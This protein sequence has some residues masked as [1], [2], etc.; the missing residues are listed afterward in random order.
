MNN[1]ETTG[2]IVGY[3]VIWILALGLHIF[4]SHVIGKAAERRGRNYW[5]F[6]WL[7]FLVSWV[8]MGIIVAVLPY[9]HEHS[10][11]KNRSNPTAPASDKTA[12]PFCAED[13]KVQAL[14]CKHCGRDIGDALKDQ[15]DAFITEQ[16]HAARD[17]PNFEGPAFE[18]RECG[19]FSP[20]TSEDAELPDN[21]PSCGTGAAFL[22]KYVPEDAEPNEELAIP[23][24]KIDGTHL[25]CRSC[26]K[27]SEFP[28]GSH[29]IP[30]GCPKC[31][32]GEAFLEIVK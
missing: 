20:M 30:E 10:T 23:D 28:G 22:H 29:T 7:S 11:S 5:A 9:D 4:L 18:C 19:V 16:E 8:I 13:V 25:H 21:C 3:V 32:S 6:F 12:C 1:G 31:G 17:Q 27:D 14:V 26:G 15:R 2:V 24:A